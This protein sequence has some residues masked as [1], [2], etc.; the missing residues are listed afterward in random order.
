MKLS[1]FFLKILL[2]KLIQSVYSKVR[3]QGIGMI[4]DEKLSFFLKLL[5]KYYGI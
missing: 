5:G 2:Y 1:Q 4:K 3:Y